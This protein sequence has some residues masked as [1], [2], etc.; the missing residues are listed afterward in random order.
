MMFLTPEKLQNSLEA[1]VR[2]E[3]WRKLGARL[4]RNVSYSYANCQCNFLITSINC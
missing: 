2:R 1:L 3:D 4:R